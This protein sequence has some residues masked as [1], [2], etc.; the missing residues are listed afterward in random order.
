MRKL[1]AV[2]A[3]LSLL[4]AASSTSSFAAGPYK[5]P[6][7]QYCKGMSKK[8]IAGQKKS[9]FAQCVTAMAQ[10]DKKPALAPSQACKGL[11]K[12][13]KKSSAKKAAKK[14][15]KQCVQ[16]GKKL[17]LDNANA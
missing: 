6:P 2:T 1:V 3:A 12:S 16:A 15:F 14:A 7:G 9:P 11:K 4:A 5:I 17:K 10:L 8:K 13:S